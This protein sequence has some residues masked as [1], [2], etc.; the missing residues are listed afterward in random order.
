VA[1]PVV[2]AKLRDNCL[3]LLSHRTSGDIKGAALSFFH[4]GK[5][6]FC[7]FDIF[8]LYYLIFWQNLC[9]FYNAFETRDM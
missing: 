8:L 2:S 4:L 9:L 6:E 1:L 5:H 3:Q 7:I